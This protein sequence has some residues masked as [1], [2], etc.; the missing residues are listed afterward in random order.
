ML[1]DEYRG[2]R[3][4]TPTEINK[5]QLSLTQIRVLVEQLVR[6]FVTFKKFLIKCQFDLC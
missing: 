1:P 4:R 2:A 3:K 5:I 6:H